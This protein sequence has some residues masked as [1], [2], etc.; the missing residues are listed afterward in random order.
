MAINNNQLARI[1][2]PSI[3]DTD[4]ANKMATAFTNINDN[5]KKI[6]SLPFLQGLQGDSYELKEYHVFEKLSSSPDELKLGNAVL[7]EEGAVLINAIFNT[8]FKSG[9]SL[10]KLRE[11]T[12]FILNNVSAFDSFIEGVKID[13]DSKIINNSIYFYVI[14]DDSGEVIQKSKHLGQYFYFLAGSV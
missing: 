2:A 12:E 13:N 5:F 3:N 7:T 10:E 1:V 14:T 4:Y 6:A 11:N 8:S 9:N